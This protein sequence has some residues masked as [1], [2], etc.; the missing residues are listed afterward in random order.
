MFE[1]RV[2]RA[3][4]HQEAGEDCIMRRPINFTRHQ[5]KARRVILV[6]H[7]ARMVKTRSLSNLVR[8]PQGKRPLGRPMHRWEDKYRMNLGK[9][10]LKIVDWIRLA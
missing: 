1:D 9:L 2:M 4:K 5:I 3:K 10:R 7:V 8:K 6:G